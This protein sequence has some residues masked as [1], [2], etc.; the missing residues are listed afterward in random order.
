VTD[1]A[2][3]DLESIKRLLILLLIKLGSDST[4]IAGA[5]GVDGS[6]VRRLVP[7]RSVKKIVL[8]KDAEP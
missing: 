8:S 5:L 7:T 3:Q 1:D 6:V 2:L 4:E